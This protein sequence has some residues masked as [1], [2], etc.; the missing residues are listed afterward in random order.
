MLYIFMDSLLEKRNALKNGE[1]PV[2]IG[3]KSATINKIIENLNYYSF[4]YIGTI[5]AIIY[6]SIIEKG[7]TGS[8]YDL[9]KSAFFFV[10]KTQKYPNKVLN[11]IFGFVSKPLERVMPKSTKNTS[12]QQQSKSHQ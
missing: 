7:V 10:D 5:V 11:N 1:K 6:N 4:G 3:T 9:V 2:D 8:I 12:K